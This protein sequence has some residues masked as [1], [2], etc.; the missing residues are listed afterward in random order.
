MVCVLCMCL[1]QVSMVYLLHYR[2]LCVYIIRNLVCVAPATTRSGAWYYGNLAR[3]INPRFIPLPMN[4]PSCDCT[5]PPTV[6]PS[7]TP[8]VAPSNIPSDA[9]SRTPSDAPSDTPTNMRADIPTDA[10]LDTPTDT[11]TEVP[12]QAPTDM[13]TNLPSAVPSL[14]QADVPSDNPSYTTPSTAPVADTGGEAGKAE[15]EG[16]EQSGTSSAS[17][18]WWVILLGVVSVPVLCTIAQSGICFG[19]VAEES[20]LRA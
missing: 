16:D 7:S 2:V 8:S 18:Q 14:V 3:F 9:P 20:S 17:E 15:P 19:F 10:P 11:P 4:D 13:P 1:C 6:V 12:S 5:R